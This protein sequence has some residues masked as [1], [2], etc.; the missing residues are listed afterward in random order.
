MPEARIE[1]ELDEG[2]LDAFVVW[3]DTPGRKPPIL[4]LSGPPDGGHG[5]ES[6]A[7][8]LSAHNYFV[9][10][11]DLTGLAADD[12]REAAWACMDYLADER[13]VDDS[14]V[15][16]LGFGGGGDMAL[17]LAADR[18]ERIAAA[19][20]YGGRG[21]SARTALEI[22]QRI[23]GLVRIGYQVGAARRRA[24]I[25]EAAFSLSGV[26][27]DT[28]VY[29]AEP[30]WPDLLDFFARALVVPPPAPVAGTNPVHRA[31]NP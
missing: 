6:T 16:A 28:E 9:I 22:S 15:G 31:L 18:A 2:A 24:G 1:L 5:G 3:P 23:N 19:A 20:A 12:R 29:E 14:R 8:R 4:L 21:F 26:L 30:R 13:R 17:R 27:F 10:V 11:P 7:R 25:L